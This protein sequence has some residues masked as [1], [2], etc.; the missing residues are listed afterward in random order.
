MFLFNSALCDDNIIYI[1]TSQ[2]Q[3]TNQI[4]KRKFITKFHLDDSTIFSNFL[5]LKLTIM[6]GI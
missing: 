1:Y 5:F 3:T 6:Q 4:F 2:I